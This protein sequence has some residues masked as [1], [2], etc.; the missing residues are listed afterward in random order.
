MICYEELGVIGELSGSDPFSY[1]KTRFLGPA[2]KVDIKDF[3]Q[4][5]LFFFG[6]DVDSFKDALFTVD[7]DH[8]SK[9][10]IHSLDD[11]LHPSKTGQNDLELVL[12]EFFLM[13]DSV[14]IFLLNRVELF[15]PAI[16][17]NPIGV[18]GFY[19]RKIL[20]L[21]EADVIMNK[22]LVFAPLNKEKRTDFFP[23][24]NNNG[25]GKKA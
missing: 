3:G 12:V 10:A 11:D 6:F 20:I 25:L 19:I 15:T 18:D 24:N 22:V 14:S 16:F 4:S 23:G 21:R 2:E 13:H 17:Q 7:G 9:K 8:R 1:G 5:G